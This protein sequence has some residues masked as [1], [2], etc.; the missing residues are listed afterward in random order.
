M[1]RI[2]DAADAVYWWL[3]HHLLIAAAM[4]AALVLAGVGIAWATGDDEPEIPSGAVAVIGNAPITEAQLTHWQEIYAKGAAG[5]GQ[6]AKPSAEASRKAAFELLAGSTFITQEAKR[7]DVEVPEA[8]VQKGVDAYFKQTGATTP[9]A[10]AQVMQSI[11]IAEEDLRY[12]QRVSLLSAE[13]RE[14][15][16]KAVPQPSAQAIADVYAKEPQRWARPSQR[17][18][19][20]VITNDE[21]SAKKARAALDSGTSFAAVVKEYSVDA[22]LAQNK[23]VIEDLKPGSNAGTVERPV[24]AAPVNE[25]Q[26]PIEVD[27]GFM[28]FEVQSA[29]ALP[30]QDLKAATPAIKRDLLTIAQAKATEGFVKDLRDRWKARTRCTTQVTSEEFCTRTRT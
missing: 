13:L 11:G 4:V 25:L 15:V 24:F 1:D 10:K 3:R 17:T 8:E 21:A 22:T 7:Q 5:S 6:A 23:G 9:E 28:V 30:A 2:L 18:V 20:A 16:S 27:G 12:Q 26:G 14:R 19:Q 29:K